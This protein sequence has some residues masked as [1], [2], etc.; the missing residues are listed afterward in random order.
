M[1]VTPE[2]IFALRWLPYNDVVQLIDSILKNPLPKD[3]SPIDINTINLLSFSSA[4]NL[5][6]MDLKEL[7]L[8]MQN[9]YET[10]INK[11]N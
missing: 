10:T 3:R 5:I 8:N 4:K 9:K 7:N 6:E 1:I 11:N 2:E